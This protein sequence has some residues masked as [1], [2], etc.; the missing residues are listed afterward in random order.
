MKRQLLS[1][2]VLCSIRLQHGIK[3]A[4]HSALH[5]AAAIGCLGVWCMRC[6]M[7]AFRSL[8]ACLFGRWMRVC[9]RIHFNF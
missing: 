4:V 6:C 8:Q 9:R 2:G 7:A 3:G 1:C 5:V